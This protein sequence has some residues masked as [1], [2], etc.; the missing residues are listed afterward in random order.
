M[1]S[2]HC[3]ARLVLLA[4]ASRIRVVSRNV[5]SMGDD[6][7]SNSIYNYMYKKPADIFILL[8]TRSGPEDT[9]RLQ[10]NG[11]VSVSSIA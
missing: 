9:A 6:Q 7:K 4:S 8:D 2:I 1:F 3:M 11:K 10:K 5:N